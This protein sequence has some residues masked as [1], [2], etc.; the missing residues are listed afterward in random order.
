[1]GIPPVG[2]QKA[3]RLLLSFCCREQYPYE[4][5]NWYYQSSRIWGEIPFWCTGVCS[6]GKALI[7]TDKTGCL[8]GS[9]PLHTAYYG[10]LH[11]DAFD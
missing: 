10:K 3:D 9:F 4:D 6:T 2:A 1:M 5:C 7:A 11:S 8:S